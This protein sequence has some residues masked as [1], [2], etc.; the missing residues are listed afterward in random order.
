MWACLLPLAEGRHIPGDCFLQEVSA[1]VL[2][3]RHWAREV[4]FRV[5][6]DC[7]GCQDGRSL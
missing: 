6:G 5:S 7:S 2:F 4:A 3:R 1:S